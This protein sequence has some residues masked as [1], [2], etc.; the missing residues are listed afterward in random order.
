MKKDTRFTKKLI[1]IGIAAMFCGMGQLNAYAAD[2]G[3]NLQGLARVAPGSAQSSFTLM[4]PELPPFAAPTDANRA[5]AQALGAAGGIMDALDNLTDPIQS[6]VNV[7]VFSPNNP[8]NLTMTA[9]VTFLGQFLDHDITLDP[10]SKLLEASNP[11]R[12]TNFRTPAFDLDSVYGAGPD[13]SS[14][15]YDTSSGDILFKIEAIPGSESVSRLGATR[16]DVPRDETGK[17][18]LAEGRNDENIIINQLQLAFLRF[19]NA[20]TANVRANHA[21][22][23]PLEVFVEARRQVRWH[24]QWIIVHEFLPMTIGSTLTETL[25]KD[26]SI[27]L[28]PRIPMEFSVAAYRF[29]HS[30]IRPSYRL[31]FGPNASSP[32]F[33]FIF[34]DSAANDASSDPTDF[35]GGKR[36]PRR[37]VDWQTFFDFGTPAPR[38]NKKIDVKLSTPMMH[39]PGFGAPTPGLPNDGVQSLASR[40]LM[41]HVNFGLASGQAIAA[42]LGVPALTPAELSEL[43]P[44]GFDKSTPLWYYVLKEAQ[45]KQNGDRLGPVGGYIVGKVFTDLLKADS[46][47]YLAAQPDWTPTLP[48]ATPGKFMVTDLLNY[49]GVVPPLQ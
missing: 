22:W 16:Y 18:I 20:V 41:R 40:N 30:Q 2:E 7:P 6:V 12:V 9:G 44:Y 10:K 21:D 11:K 3:N 36:A 5:A 37:F 26:R 17:A 28:N 27:N 8:D 24:Y 13:E 34:E 49:A 43:A 1:S 48:S 23:S 25:L 29:G 38:N 45:V 46:T 39:L 15:L 33:G 32:F 42:R 35:R 4:F 31:N 47:S 19:H 14:E